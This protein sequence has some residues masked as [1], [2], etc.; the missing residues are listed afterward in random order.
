MDDVHVRKALNWAM[1]KAAYM[2]IIGGEVEGVP[3]AHVIP[4]GMMGG[5]NADYA[6]Y[7]TPDNRG[8]IEKAKAEIAQSKYDTNGDGVCDGDVCTIQ[9]FAVT[10][11]NEA[12]KVLELMDENFSNFG[13]HL[14]IQTQ[15][16]NT[17][18]AKCAEL[19]AHRALCQ[20]GW[21]KDYPSPFTFFEPLL[22]GG[23]NGSNYSFMGT[24]EDALVEAG[25]EVPDN[26]AELTIDPDIAA[27]QAIPVG[28]EQDQCWADLDVKVMEQLVPVLPRRFPND[29]DVLGEDIANYAYCQFT[30]VG[31]PDK[32]ALASAAA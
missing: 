2:R 29:V 15:N 31:A 30:G 3:A 18:V 20:A 14:E 7:G 28:P 32:M 12:I 23:E 26:F 25:Y 13:I 10:N 6:P 21:G 4:P 24:T 27:C 16:Y 17:L 22:N 11:D 8:D 5:L 19:A 1:D 9:A